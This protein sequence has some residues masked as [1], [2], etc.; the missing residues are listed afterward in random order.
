MS[1]FRTLV[2]LLV[3]AP[4]F[5]FAG[6]V[7]LYE[8]STADIRLASAGWSSR[9]QDPSTL[10]TNPAGMSRIPCRTAE[11][12]GE[13]FYSHVKF[14]R[15][16]NTTASG[17]NGDASIVLPSSS[18]FYVQP[19]NQRLTWGVGFLG[20]FG[21]TAHYNTD[22][23]GRYYVLRTF[24]EGFSLVPAISY[25]VT[26]KLS[27]G[28]GLNAM[29]GIFRQ[30]NAVNN[31][32]DGL[33]DGRLKLHDEDLACG[34]IVGLLYEFTP[35]TRIGVQY[36]SEV[37]L[38]FKCKT[39]FR[40]IG[41]TLNTALTNTGL[42]NSQVTLVANVPQSV[43]VSGYHDLNRC[44]TV[45][46]DAG[47]QQW[48]RFQKVSISL[49]NAASTT[50]T[51]SPQYEDTW[52]VAVGAEYHYNPC[53]TFS[54]GIAYDSSMVTNENR[55]LD[56]PVG[57]QWRFG[58]GARWNYAENLTFDFCYEL[59]WSGNLPIDQNRGTLTSRVAGEF[60]NMYIQFLSANV[61]WAF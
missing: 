28:V 50:L 41:P 51:A 17:P 30:T 11:L 34:A 54:G 18:L 49:D 26:D 15:N 31:V 47:W 53:W 3:C 9:A 35:C 7:T 48:S 25:Q 46:A 21:A 6:G 16:G 43:M 60:S 44:W 12:G 55:T 38:K 29:Y 36:M 59:M 39:H 61:I 24:L 52:H 57:A 5:L 37:H 23:V 32:L 2:A 1:L 20:Y 22:W 40:G 13:L 33:P 14:D 56:L 8:L 27:V 19:Y 4:L 45:M 58:T 10:F 42:L